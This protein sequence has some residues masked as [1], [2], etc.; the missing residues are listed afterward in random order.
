MEF[1]TVGEKLTYNFVNSFTN[2]LFDQRQLNM[3]TNVG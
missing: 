3:P 1:V 2:R